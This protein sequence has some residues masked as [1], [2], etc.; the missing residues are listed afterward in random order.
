MQDSTRIKYI[1]GL[2]Q[3]YIKKPPNSGGFIY[4]KT[5][6]LMNSFLSFA[7]HFRWMLT[8]VK[9]ISYQYFIVN[10]SVYYLV[11]SF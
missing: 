2:F 9:N 1:V 3:K 10:N 11:M 5:H 6:C 8:C 7:I 4:L